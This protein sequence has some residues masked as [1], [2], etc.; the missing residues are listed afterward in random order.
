MVEH[1]VT[2]QRV[3]LPRVAQTVARREVQ[4]DEQVLDAGDEGRRAL[5]RVRKRVPATTRSRR[6]SC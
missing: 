4:L 2:H 1:Q 6:L 5:R 3:Q